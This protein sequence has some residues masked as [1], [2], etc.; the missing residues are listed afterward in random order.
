MSRKWLV[1]AALAD[2]GAIAPTASAFAA[3][4]GAQPFVAASGPGR[5]TGRPAGCRLDRLHQRLYTYG[6]LR[7]AGSCTS[8][9]ITAS[10]YSP[11]RISGA[12]GDSA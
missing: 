9:A 2:A 7:P 1:A 8:G 11:P 10:Q 12:P 6:G 3:G 4:H 5:R